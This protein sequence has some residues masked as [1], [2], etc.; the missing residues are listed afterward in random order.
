MCAL[1][2]SLLIRNDHVYPHSLW[3]DFAIFHRFFFAYGVY[4]P[5]WSLWF[6]DQGVSATDIGVLVGIGFATR[7]VANLVLTPR[8]HRVEQLMPALRWL[9]F[10][11]ML[12]VGFHFLRA[13]VFG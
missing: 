10:A 11:A 3:L 7:C 5:F 4:L 12:F 1:Y 8:L 9:S 13:A 6:E 2:T